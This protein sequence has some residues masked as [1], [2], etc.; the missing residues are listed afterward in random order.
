MPANRRPPRP[1][2]RSRLYSVLARTVY[3]VLARTVYN[4]LTH[5]VYSIPSGLFFCFFPKFA[6]VVLGSRIPWERRAQRRLCRKRVR[7]C[8]RDASSLGPPRPA[9][10]RLGPRA[11]GTDALLARRCRFHEVRMQ[12]AFVRARVGSMSGGDRASAE[13]VGTPRG[14]PG[15]I[16]GLSRDCTQKIRKFF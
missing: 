11:A 5:T 10:A 6:R 12:N 3:S 8:R 9:A 7:G 2:P 15:T 13:R 4:V 14:W 16:T 1:A